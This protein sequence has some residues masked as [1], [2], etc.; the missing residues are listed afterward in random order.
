M[1]Q[2]IYTAPFKNLSKALFPQLY[3]L[4][5]C[6]TIPHRTFLLYHTTSLP[7]HFA[8]PMQLPSSLFTSSLH[9]VTG[10]DVELYTIHKHIQPIPRMT[11]TLPSYPRSFSASAA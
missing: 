9:Q 1:Q 3:Y 4:L 7:Y 10:S 5:P 8:S 11:S 2:S 6:F